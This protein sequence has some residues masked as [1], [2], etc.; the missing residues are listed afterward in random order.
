MPTHFRLFFFLKYIKI[1]DSDLGLHETIQAKKDKNKTKHNI[2][3]N[4]FVDEDWSSMFYYFQC[5][6]YIKIHV[7]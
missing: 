2:L 7:R 1:F 6:I 5:Y 3:M 4:L